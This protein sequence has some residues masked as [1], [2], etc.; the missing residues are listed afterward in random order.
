[1][2]TDPYKQLYQ[3]ILGQ[4]PDAEGLAYWKQQFGDEISPEE[5]TQF[6]NTALNLIGKQAFGRDLTDAEKADLFKLNTATEALNWADT[7]GKDWLRGNRYKE[8]YQEILGRDP[9]A[10]G[11]AYWQQQFGD[12]ISPEEK[13]QFK[14]TAYNKLIS[15]AYAG[16]GRKS[17]DKAGVDYWL[18]QLQTGAIKPQDFSSVFSSTAEQAYGPLRNQVLNLYSANKGATANPTEEDIRYWSNQILDKGFDAAKTDF[19]NTVKQIR[20]D[21]PDLAKKIDEERQNTGVGVDVSGESGL[22][23]AYGP[24]VERM[25]ERSSAL[26]DTDFEK[27]DDKTLTGTGN[28]LYKARSGINTLGTPGQFAKAQ[29]ALEGVGTGLTS[30]MGQSFANPNFQ[31][32]A[33]PDAVKQAGIGGLDASKPNASMVRN[34]YAQ[35]PLAMKANPQGPDQAALDYWTGQ[36]GQKG[37][38]PSFQDFTNTVNALS[39]GKAKGGEVVNYDVGGTVDAN[40]NANTAANANP[41][42]GTTVAYGGQNITPTQASYMSPY[43]QNVVD[44]QQREAKRQSDILGQQEAAKAVGAGAYGGSRAGLVEAERQ[45]NLLNQLGGIQATGLQSAF[46]QGLGQFN[47]ERQ[48]NLQAQQAATNAA[49][50]LGQTGYQQGML[51]LQ[52]L[53]QQ[54]DLGLADRTFDYNEFLR[55]Q[56]YPYEN[57]TFMRNQLT[58]LPISASAT[59]IDPLSNALTGGI[60][61]AYLAQL[62]SQYT[63]SK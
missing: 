22:R 35:N 37:Y 45:R 5:K 2:A 20:E 23:E 48:L 62:L 18:N 25:L 8:L 31:G 49:Q 24:Y 61:S 29:T 27:Y 63:G 34:W 21:D 19:N 16:L 56:K 50:A 39:A 52:R 42:T 38:G 3:E 47:T 4:D 13:T 9:D 40:A 58:G 59:G 1:M 54:A 53:K 41:T 57:L 7:K 32:A 6:K 51:D 28:A 15:D 14:N 30:L 12:E 33:S 60:S 26:A 46:T 10:E 11:L 44:V 36:I 17:P 55:E 43:M